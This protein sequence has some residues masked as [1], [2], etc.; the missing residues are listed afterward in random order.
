M[1]F[2]LA[3]EMALIPP[4]GIGRKM[5]LDNH[6]RFIL[7]HCLSPYERQPRDEPDARVQQRDAKQDPAGDG[8]DREMLEEDGREDQQYLGYQEY[9]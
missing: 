2:A 6:I 9:H 3:G 8:I 5:R 1:Q 4:A 7:V